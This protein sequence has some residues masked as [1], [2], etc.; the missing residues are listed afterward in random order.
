MVPLFSLT[1]INCTTAPLLPH[2]YLKGHISSAEAWPSQALET[3]EEPM[4]LLG[5]HLPASILLSPAKGEI[6]HDTPA[7]TT[8]PG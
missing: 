8:F 5:K 6:Q 1:H 4:T 3:V 7:D 2:P